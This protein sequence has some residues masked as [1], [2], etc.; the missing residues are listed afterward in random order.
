MKDKSARILLFGWLV[1]RSVKRSI[2]LVGSEK[3]LLMTL[4]SFCPCGSTVLAEPRP[5]LLKF[6]NPIFRH[7]EG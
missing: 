2:V 7:L 5:P 4:L 6:L 3:G 1:G